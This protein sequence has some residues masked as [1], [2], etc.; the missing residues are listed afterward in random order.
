MSTRTQM[1]QLRRVAHR[2]TT[3]SGSPEA[4]Y[5]GLEN[6]ESWTGRYLRG[7]EDDGK[8]VADSA[9]GEG[10]ATLF[11][12]GD[13]LFGKLR[14]YLAKVWRATFSGRCTAEALVLRPTVKIDSRY[15]KWLLLEPRFVDEVDG[16]TYGSKMPRA[17]W[18]FIG[19]I[20]VPLPP[21]PEQQRIANLLDTKTAAID[22]LLAK[23]ERLLAVLAEERQALVTQLVTKGLDPNA[24]MRASEVEWAESL[25]SHWRAL[26]IKRLARPGHRTFTDGDWIEA[27][28]ITDRG[29]R[30]LQTGNVG[31]GTFRE[32]GGRFISD[33]T[34]AALR[35]TLLEAGDVMIC[36]LD[37]PVGRACLAPSLG[38]RMVTS[39]D[40]AIL[41]LDPEH[42]AR[43]IVYALSS[44]R[45]LE[46]VQALVRVGGGF[47][48]RVS[49]T[50]LGD[51]RVP[52]PPRDEQR[53]IADHLDRGT[54]TLREIEQGLLAAIE[55][56][57]EY[58]RA[59]ITAGVTGTL[60][61]G[62]L[63]SSAGVANQLEL[64]LA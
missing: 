38:T 62:A 54:H 25:P 1:I 26:P 45:Y 58:R 64:A 55:R 19:R 22:R 7:G 14:P 52:V 51:F 3:K 11:D 20:E 33:E 39:V 15:L 60:T 57:R 35:C 48:Y 32:Q 6:I 41:K 63:E 17:E 21:L 31:I 42:D 43:F 18:D 23:K 44:P 30:L 50:M 10:L 37:G 47:R 8:G 36:R 9:A 29:V 16:S 49:R 13:V 27:P 46:W 34:F 53:A 2:I 61:T 5:V 59:T 12:E 40:N 28:Y 4:I 24:P 56:L